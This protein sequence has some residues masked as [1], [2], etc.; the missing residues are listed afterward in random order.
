VIGASA[1]GVEAL[2]DI[3]RGLPGTLEAAVFVVL[4]IPAGSPSTLPAILSRAGALPAR[5]PGPGAPF[6]RGTIYVAPPDRHM[7]LKADRVLTVRTGKESRHRPAIDPLFR[8]AARDHGS[9]VIGVVLTGAL[10]DGTAGLAAVKRQGGIAVVQDPK[11]AL[12]PSMP[13]SA[14]ANVAVDHSVPL[15]EIP[16]LLARLTREDLKIPGVAA[17]AGLGVDTRRAMA[18]RITCR[19]HG[20]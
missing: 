17:P 2:R 5:H 13:M 18:G 11:D 8:S 7:V 19:A 1:G 9:R 16:A 14:L 20:S 4:H 6:E 3:A 10:D 15:A 12:F